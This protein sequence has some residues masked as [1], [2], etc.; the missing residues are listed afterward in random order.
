MAAWADVDGPSARR[1]VQGGCIKDGGDGLCA[2]CPRRC[3]QRRR[4]RARQC[5][6][7]WRTCTRRRTRSGTR[8]G[9]PPRARRAARP[10]CPTPARRLV[11]TR[12]FPGLPSSTPTSVCAKHSPLLSTINPSPTTPTLPS[13]IPISRWPVLQCRG[14]LPSATCLLRHT[15]TRPAF[16]TRH[17]PLPMP[18][19]PR[20]TTTITTR[21]I[22]PLHSQP[23]PQLALIRT[24]NWRPCPPRPS[25]SSPPPAVPPSPKAS[26]SPSRLAARLLSTRTQARAIRTQPCAE[27]A[28]AARSP[29]HTTP[30][31]RPFSTATP[32]Y[33]P[34]LRLLLPQWA[35][36]QGKA[37][38]QRVLLLHLRL[39]ASPVVFHPFSR[40]RNSRSP[41]PPHR[42][43]ARAGGGTRHTS[44]VPSRDVAAP[45]LGGSTC[46]V[47]LP[48]LF[49]VLPLAFSLRAAPVLIV[50]PMFRSNCGPFP[51]PRSSPLSYRGKTV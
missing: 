3:P 7:H 1:E 46:V 23:A 31:T 35:A 25:S 6:R 26:R 4:E 22:A 34:H 37:L 14:I 2:L 32:R 24:S 48:S 51:F 47:S 5:T 39:A 11:P 45:S 42:L 49:A 29:S 30:Q 50:A 33:F 40:S 36:V 21:L 12:P 43:Q 18:S 27:T 9:R 17:P 38:L 8:P 20:P 13:Q 15:R 19:P 10:T 41:R 16:R 44:S 28:D